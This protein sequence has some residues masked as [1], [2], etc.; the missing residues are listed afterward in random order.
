[1]C[2]RSELQI[3][4]ILMVHD[5]NNPQNEQLELLHKIIKAFNAQLHFLQITIE[6]SINK[7]S[8]IESDMAKFAA[9]NNIQ[10]FQ[11]HIIKDEQIESGVI[12]FNQMNNMDVICIGTHGKGSIFHKSL[13]EKLINHLF[14]PIISFQLK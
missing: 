13:T 9:L 8:E 4:N 10:Q 11:T 14:K 12:H 3:N 7:E 2:D 1:M 5:F 6:E